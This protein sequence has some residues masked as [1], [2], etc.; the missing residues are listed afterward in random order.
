MNLGT[1]IRE[2]KAQVNNLQ[3]EGALETGTSRHNYSSNWIQN[4]STKSP[5]G[6]K[7]SGFNGYKK[8]SKI[9]NFSMFLQYKEEGVA[10][11]SV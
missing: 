1:A 9:R 5:I 11:S 7:N 10:T 3:E 2:I 6:F 4:I 8:V